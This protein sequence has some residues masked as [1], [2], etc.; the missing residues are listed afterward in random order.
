MAG[1]ME[2][3]RA[4]TADWSRSVSMFALVLFIVSAL[5][6]RFLLL[7]TVPFL[8]LLGIVGALALTG[9][10]LGLLALVQMWE[11]GLA[12]LGAA[13]AGFIVALL[14]LAPYGW[15]AYRLATHPQ[16]VDIS[17]DLEDPPALHR[18]PDLRSPPMNAL[19]PL[20]DQAKA[21]Q[22]E[23]YPELTGRRYEY[24]PE[25]V[26]AAIAGLLAD[27]GWVVVSDA[28]VEGNALSIEAVARSYLL[29][30]ASDVAIRVEDRANATYVDMRSASRYGRHDLGDNAK[31]IERF[32]NDLDARMEALDTL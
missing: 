21:M 30:F 23:A 17:T 1:I 16:L 11:H 25:S 15:S 7:E 9:L 32:F 31:R 10:L 4:R 14:A 27:R 19:E 6:H 20:T 3:R 29:G 18:A 22:A 12:G 8:W 24:A 28:E 26:A 2:V 13:V 5:A